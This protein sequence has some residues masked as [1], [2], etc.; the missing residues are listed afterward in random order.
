[1]TTCLPIIQNDACKECA[2][3]LRAEKMTKCIHVNF[4]EGFSKVGNA[5]I[6]MKEYMDK[7]KTSYT[8]TMY[9]VYNQDMSVDIYYELKL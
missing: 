7:K 8:G 2:E 1:M 4:T 6:R 3:Y 9:E 5:H